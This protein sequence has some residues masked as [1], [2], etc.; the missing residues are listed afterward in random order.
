MISVLI[1][2]CS[3]H[4]KGM[5]DALRNN[6]DN[7]EIRVIGIDCDPNHLLH[8]GVDASYVVPRID[9]PRYIGN[10]M[11]ICKEEKVDVILPFITGELELMARNA[12]KFE[13]I[14]VK[15]SV[16]SLASLEIANNKI[17]LKDHYTSCMPDQRV[18][19]GQKHIEETKTYV[20]AMEDDGKKVCC[21]LPNKCG[22]VGFV[23]IDN[24]KGKDITIVNKANTNHYV[25]IDMMEEYMKHY[26][27]DMIFQEYYE[28]YD[29]S[30]SLL[31]DHGKVLFQQ[32]FVGYEMS[33]GSVV[34]GKI[35]DNEI[36]YEIT[37]E[38]VK[39]LRLDGNACLDFIVAPSG[40]TKLLEINPRLSASL[41]FV[42]AAGLNLP[43]LRCKQLLGYD[44][45]KYDVKVNKELRMEKF[46]ES[47]YF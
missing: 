34:N 43:Y 10:V 9:D 28:G 14:G 37:E 15:V 35:A 7:E 3:K 5:I 40:E 32:G 27:G 19:R 21:K 13:D 17:E 6:Y 39:D 11:H 12:K 44:V 47:E 16:A 26:D 30:V 24:E 36:A 23:I 46:Y 45:T 42:A 18:F 20:K 2:G 33:F 8:K 31:A 41:P 29:Y 25:T 22:G 1:T 38:I 4:S